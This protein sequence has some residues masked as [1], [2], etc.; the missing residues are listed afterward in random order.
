MTPDDDG[1]SNEQLAAQAQQGG[2]AGFE[3]LVKRHRAHLYRLARRHVGQ[4]DDAYDVVQDTFIA[5]W[6]ALP[7][8]DP[9]RPF[10][11]WLRTIMLNKC[12]DFGRRQTVRRWLLRTYATEPS[13]APTPDPA[14]EAEDENS[15]AREAIR[16]ERL[17]RAISAL[18]AS[19][20]E[21]LLLTTVAGLTQEAVAAQL[22]TTTKAI[23]MRLR[24]ARQQLA[25]VL[26]EL[27]G[28]G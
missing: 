5:A 23:E 10:L 11:P 28:E 3:T 7:R 15:E 24:R 26:A 22:H 13:L 1:V 12:R 25:K 27:D 9:G 4:S 8:Y 17:D 21:P 14:S 16:L 6:E 19:Y 18:P 20:K 2:R